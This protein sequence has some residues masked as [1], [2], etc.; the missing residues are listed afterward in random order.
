M[1]CNTKASLFISNRQHQV[2]SQFDHQ[3]CN[4]FII[5]DVKKTP[6]TSYFFIRLF[7]LTYSFNRCTCNIFSVWNCT[8][9][10]RC[11]CSHLVTMLPMTERGVTQQS[12]A[13]VMTSLLFAGFV[14]RGLITLQRVESL[15]GGGQSS[16]VSPLL[17][18]QVFFLFTKTVGEKKIANNFVLLVV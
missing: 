9:Y 12:S 11:T 14:S 6:S 15:I 16:T 13:V 4:L 5:T 8:E 3:W 17:Q 2:L 7:S 1:L 18:S 10:F